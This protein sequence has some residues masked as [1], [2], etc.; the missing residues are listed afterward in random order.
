MASSY[1]STTH[2]DFF[3]V[4][5]FPATESLSLSSKETLRV[6]LEAGNRNFR[7]RKLREFLHALDWFELGSREIR[8]LRE[9]TLDK[10]APRSRELVTSELLSYQENKKSKKQ[11]STERRRG[12]RL[13]VYEYYRETVSSEDKAL[14]ESLRDYELNLTARDIN[15]RYYFTLDSFKKI[16]DFCNAPSDIRQRKI[17]RFKADVTQY[18]KNHQ[19]QTNPNQSEPLFSFDDWCDEHG[20]ESFT[21][22]GKNQS[23]QQNQHQSQKKSGHSSRPKTPCTAPSLSP[24]IKKALNCMGVTAGTPW[25]EIKSTFRKLTLTHHPDVNGGDAD[26][27]KRIISAYERLKRVYT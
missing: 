6:Y 3:A 25:K 27:M 11:E 8:P 21:N 10:L 15:W 14:L 17:E 9:Q 24:E 4:H 5:R 13:R 18:L 2:D 20:E 26:T 19:K 22:S 16:D 23:Q 7:T 12:Y 1:Q